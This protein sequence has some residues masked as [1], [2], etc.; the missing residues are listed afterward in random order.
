[1]EDLLPQTITV[2][3]AVDREFTAHEVISMHSKYFQTGETQS[4]RGCD[5]SG[6]F[7]WTL[8]RDTSQ[9]WFCCEV[10]H[11]ATD[12]DESAVGFVEGLW[13]KDVAEIF[14]T[15]ST[16][17]HTNTLHQKH[18][19][20]NSYQEFN[21]SPSGAWWSACFSDYRQRAAVTTQPT[22]NSL[23]TILRDSSWLVIAA[24]DINSCDVVFDETS[25]VHI[26]AIYHAPMD[27]YLTSYKGP[28]KFAP[29]F[30]RLDCFVPLIFTPVNTCL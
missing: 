1:M 8:A 10:P 11:P 3:D 13:S 7:N 16:K 2:H 5:I 24:I 4:W 20:A 29:D 14:F 26:S 21:F 15:S 19:N 17:K 9:L 28:K 27:V 30:H 6:P 22:L 25:L 18:A 12:Y 23:Q